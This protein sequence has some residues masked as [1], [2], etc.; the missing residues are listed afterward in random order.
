MGDK[1]DIVPFYAQVILTKESKGDKNDYYLVSRHA[2][3]SSK[4][5]DNETDYE[6]ISFKLQIPKQRYELL[7]EKMG[8]KHLY[9]LGNLELKVE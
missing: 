9:L 6:N 1:K 5:S 7:K 4:N 2:H 8:N 3:L